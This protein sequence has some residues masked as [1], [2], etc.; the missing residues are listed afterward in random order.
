MSENFI[1]TKELIILLLLSL[2]V[3][4]ITEIL[5]ASKFFAPIRD[6]FRAKN[7]EQLN[8]YNHWWFLDNV[9]HCGYCMSVWVS[10]SIAWLNVFV[11]TNMILINYILFVFIIHGLSN[12]IH[13]GYELLRRG[14]ATY[15]DVNMN[16]KK[17]TDDR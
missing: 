17:V 4:R 13:V 15:L 16:Y 5:V 8:T 14:R 7:L 1:V 2:A 12:I 9:F 10:V 11:I 6:I 3:E